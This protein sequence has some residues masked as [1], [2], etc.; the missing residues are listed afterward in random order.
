MSQSEELVIKS[1]VH[2]L[3]HNVVEK[4]FDSIELQIRGTT[5]SYKQFTDSADIL[6][7]QVLAEVPLEP[8][9]RPST[10]T[11]GL[12]FPAPCDIFHPKPQPV[13]CA[14]NT[15]AGLRC[16]AESYSPFTLCATHW[17]YYRMHRF[18][19]PGGAA[20]PGMAHPDDLWD[21]SNPYSTAAQPADYALIPLPPKGP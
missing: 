18:L 14:A 15:L 11:I 10:E 12:Q 13:R 4:L 9:V 8:V 19:P 16:R 21:R 2:V 17:R 7:D 6:L 3:F 5:L 20:E 1:D